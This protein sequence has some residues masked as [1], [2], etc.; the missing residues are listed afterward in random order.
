V[1]LSPPEKMLSTD[2][3]CGLVQ[4]AVTQKAD[5]SPAEKLGKCVLVELK[6]STILLFLTLQWPL[7]LGTGVSGK[8]ALASVNPVPLEQKSG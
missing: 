8:P 2:T 7:S 1:S 6:G 3:D 5:E 4:S